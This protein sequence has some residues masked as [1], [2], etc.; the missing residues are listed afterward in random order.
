MKRLFVIS[1]GM[2]FSCL[3]YDIHMQNDHI[4]RECSQL[5]SVEVLIEYKVDEKDLL[6]F[7]ERPLRR[8]NTFYHKY[9]WHYV[10]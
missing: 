8:R 2:V 10:H 6:I 4:D 3:P 7:D 9:R 5:V 1:L